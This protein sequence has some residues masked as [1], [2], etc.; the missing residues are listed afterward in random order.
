MEEALVDT[1]LVAFLALGVS[2][3]R[4]GEILLEVGKFPRRRYRR[5]WDNGVD[6][7]MTAG[8]SFPSVERMILS[9]H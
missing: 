7:D 3:L 8:R 5:S 1:V 9:H 4:M 2:L 6:L